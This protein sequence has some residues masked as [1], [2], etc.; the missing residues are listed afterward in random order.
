MLK[1]MKIFS[2]FIISAFVLASLTLNTLAASAIKVD[3]NGKPVKLGN[4]PYIAG[5]AVMLPLQEMAQALGANVSW[6]GV[7]N[8]VTLLRGNNISILKKG[9]STVYVNG[10]AFKLR[11]AASVTKGSIY[12]SEDFIQDVFG[13]QTSYNSKTSKLS[14]KIKELPVYY[15]KNFRIRYLDNGCKLVTDGENYKILLVPRGETAPEGIVANKKISIPPKNVMAASSTFV[16]QMAKLNVLDSL[17]AVTTSKNTWFIPKVKELVSQGKIKYVGGDNME[18]P[19]YELVKAI[20]PDLVF[21]YTGTTG[22][23]YVMK[24]FSELGIP[25]AVE[26][27]SQESDYLGRLEWIKFIAAFYDKELEAEKILNDAVKNINTVTA[28]VAG[29][30]KPKVAWGLSWAGKVYVAKYDSYVGKWI[31]SCGGDYVFKNFKVGTDTQVSAENFYAL[32]KD[33]DVFIFSSTTNYM[34]SPTI[35]QI[36]KENPLFANIKAVKNGNVWAYAPDWWQ[37]IPDADVFVKDIAA[38]FHP[39]AFSGYK[40]VKLVKLPKN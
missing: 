10:K 32:A 13:F 27:E 22:Q 16:G 18:P 30:P 17:K 11:A 26:N 7:N 37:T 35:N 6:D 28:K 39:G 3:I 4:Q 2:F 25:F 20:S 8:N 21:V 24:K 29:L 36:I 31:N 1:K 19:D 40:P 34:K 33:A 12:V 9:K 15:S 5:S 38:V 14:I 23:Q